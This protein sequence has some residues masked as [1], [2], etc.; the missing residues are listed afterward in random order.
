MSVQSTLPP[1]SSDTA[2][3][4]A[5]PETT[6]F[7]HT[8]PPPPETAS[9]DID[10]TTFIISMA[11][12]VLHHLGMALP[13]EAQPPLNLALA[14]NAIDTLV[15][16]QAK[17]KGNLTAEEAEL[18]ATLLYDLRVRFVQAA[19]AKEAAPAT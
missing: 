9:H 13:D 18:L 12:S 6:G 17:T 10:F 7:S 19:R 1:D 3:P 4:T 2:A 11:T 15:M 5:S 16:L 8:A 14:Q